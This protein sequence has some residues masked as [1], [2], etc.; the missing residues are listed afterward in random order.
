ML[1]SSLV[2][3]LQQQ[4]QHL[5]QSRKQKSTKPFTG[6]VGQRQDVTKI[7]DS[8]LSKSDGEMLPTRFGI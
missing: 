6:K 7:S 3:Q 1:P 2:I 8:C 5:A 4:S